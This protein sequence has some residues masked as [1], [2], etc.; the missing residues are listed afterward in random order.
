MIETKT[1]DNIIHLDRSIGLIKIDV[2]GAELSVLQGAI[3]T[4]KR[5][6]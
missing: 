4:I 6:K 5:N 2:E 3:E 1:L